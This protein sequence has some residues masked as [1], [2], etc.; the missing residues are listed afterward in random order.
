MSTIY[1]YI[2][3]YIFKKFKDNFKV[4][5]NPYEGSTLQCFALNNMFYEILFLK[6]V[7]TFKV[8]LICNGS[9][10]SFFSIFS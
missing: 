5:T 9:E 2:Y 1:I 7:E 3:I 4:L 6:D 10:R 8:Y